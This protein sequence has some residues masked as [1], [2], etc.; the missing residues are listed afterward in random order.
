MLYALTGIL[1]MACVYGPKL[2]IRWV[3][4]EHS[5]QIDSMPGTG[6]ELAEHLIKRFEI[7]DCTVEQTADFKDHYDPRDIT[8]RLG[9]ANYDGKSLT[10]VAV[11]DEKIFRLRKR[12]LP[13][14]RIFRQIGIF[15][16]WLIPL[17]GLLLKAPSAMFAVL[18]L[19]FLF[20]ILGALSYLLVLPEEWDAS[21][22]KALP[23]LIEGEYIQEDQIKPVRRILRAAA[24]TY[25]ASALADVL[26]ISRWIMV[27]LRR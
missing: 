19:C 22:N 11:A 3:F 16:L 9:Q 8:V 10:A 23:I 4:S 2:W 12:Y 24:I 13:A 14:A 1:L 20:Q 5:K 15:M 25:F 27:L 17:I 7:D 21:F 26:N 18:A 6:G